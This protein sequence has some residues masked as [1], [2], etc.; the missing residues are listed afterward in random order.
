MKEIEMKKTNT[1][2]FHSYVDYKK[3]TMKIKKT[4]QMNKTKTKQIC[5]KQSSSGRG[6][7]DNKMGKVVNCM[8]TGGE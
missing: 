7:G 4:K 5:R 3:Q 2:W 8:V 1:M 6:R